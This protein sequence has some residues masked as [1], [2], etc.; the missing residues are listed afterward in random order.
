M[1]VRELFILISTIVVVA[2]ISIALIWP[3]V[4]CCFIVVGPIILMGVFDI[5]QKRHTIR[6]NFPVIGRFR[7]VL[8]SVRPEIMQ[9]FVETDTEGRPLNRILRS[10]VYRR[11]K[12]ETDTE[13]FGTQMDL[14]H[15]GYEWMEHSMYAKN[16]PKDIGEFPRL[17]IGGKDCKQPYSSSLL[18]ISAMSFG[19]LSD[20]AIMAL[21]KGAKI[22]VKVVSAIII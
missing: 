14:Y 12:G 5:F 21:N 17:L 22:Q 2:I 8:E 4:L 9:Y 13:P 20:N 19:S 1:K 11:A 10:V 3:P 15:S 18:N 6:R 7:Y 16:N